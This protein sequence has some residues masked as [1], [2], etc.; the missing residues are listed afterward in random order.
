MSEPKCN[1]SQFIE[2]ICETAD[3]CT[4]AV[5]ITPCDG[6]KKKTGTCCFWKRG[7]GEP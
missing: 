1:H 3:I 4:L 6:G 2:E 7:D 5:Y